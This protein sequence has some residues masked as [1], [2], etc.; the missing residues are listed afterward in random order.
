MEGNRN[1]KQ[2]QAAEF[3]IEQKK[4]EEVIKIISNEILHYIQTRKEIAEYIIEARKKSLE[5]FEDDEDKIIEYF[6]HERFIKEKAFSTIDKRLKEFTILELSPYF[7]RVDFVESGYGEDSIYIGRF[8]VT[9]TGEEEALVIDWRAPVAALFYENGIGEASYKAPSGSIKVDILKKRQYIIKKKKLLGL[10]DTAVDVKD[11]ILQMMLSKNS[12][13]KLTDIVMTIQK[14]QDNIIRQP[15][16]KF[17]VVN[18]VAGSG[19]T[20][21]ALHRVAYLLYN[22]REILQDKVLILGPNSIFMEYI[23]SVLPSL[24]EVGVNQQ[25]YSSF[26]A[27]I[28]DLNKNE[29][30]SSKQYMERMLSNDDKFIKQIIYKNSDKFIEHLDELVRRTDKDYHRFQDV[31]YSGKTAVTQAEIYKMYDEYY[32]QMPLFRR[33]KKIKR[34]IYSKLRDERN[35]KVREINIEYESRLK[36]LND[37]ERNLQQ[38][39]IEFNRRL[40]IREAV[41][42]VIDLKKKLTWL[43]NPDIK[44][45]YSE[46][47]EDEV[48]YT[49][50]DMTAL[51][52]LRI[53]FEGFKLDYEIKHVVID[54]AQ[55]YSKLA[56]I[57]IKQLTKCNGMTIVGDS[58]QRLLPLK[59]EL[60]IENMESVADV[61]EVEY[62]KLTKSYRST[63]EIMEY[64]NKFLKRD[65]SVPVVRNGKPVD[66][67][68]VWD[69][70]QLKHKIMEIIDNYKQDE[71][72]SIAVIC[73]DL[74]ATE[75]LGKLL[76][77]YAAIIDKEDMV[78]KGGVVI[79]PSYLAKGLEFDGVII[80]NEDNRIKED[81]AK[82]VMATR[83]LHRLSVIHTLK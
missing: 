16:N 30:M 33:M 26:A 41:K 72:E 74:K 54:E 77:G 15:R 45:L 46:M 50:D 62:F 11:D 78:Y 34:I 79:I 71:N 66:E 82:Y 67:F 48:L 31:V 17:V 64:A 13:A 7:G 83:A 68:E 47:M 56:F 18:G 42:E 28:L 69:E 21:I 51:L 37:E 40:K 58:N 53:S 10:F 59:G 3:D 29:V 12:E 76:K 4:L 14:E 49:V 20:T 60:A 44:Q 32:V 73:R 38:N 27:D 6:D 52:Y 23:A 70:T 61:S 43:N 2:E 57:V 63:V 65:L 19:K 36:L 75:G 1:L 8:G 35:N 80:I 55:D 81:K 39:S 24:G 9:P 5:E 25:T 22:F